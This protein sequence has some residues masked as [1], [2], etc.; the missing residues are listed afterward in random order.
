MLVPMKDLLVKA[1]KEGYGITAPN[2]QG[3]DT[4][5]AVISVAEELNAP[6]IIDLNHHVHPDN[7]VEFCQKT[8]DLINASRIPIAFNLDHGKTYAELMFAIRG[9]MSSYMIDRSQTPFEQNVRETQEAVKMA[10][11][12]GMSVEAEL[13]YVGRANNYE[14]DGYTN[15]TKPEEAARFIKETDVDCLAVAIGNAH[16][17]Y[18]NRTP[19]IRFDLLAEIAEACGDTPLVMHGGSGTGDE[20]LYRAVRNGISKVNLCN[21]L[22]MAARRALEAGIASKEDHRPYEYH[23]YFIEGYKEQLRHFVKLFGQNDRV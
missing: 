6:M 12:L 21:D 3:E 11:P 14:V 13:G 1:K 16:G 4:V 19:D 17:L 23:R 18:K 8:V 20:N 9:G 15:L 7:F 5:R 2:V 10:R 22:F